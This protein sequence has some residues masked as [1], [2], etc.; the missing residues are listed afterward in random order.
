MKFSITGLN[1]RS[2]P[3]EVRERLAFDERSIPDA[4]KILRNQPGVVEGMILSTFNLV[5]I[6]VS[7]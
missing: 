1:H 4:L 6:A 3:V 7:F 5:E 2:A